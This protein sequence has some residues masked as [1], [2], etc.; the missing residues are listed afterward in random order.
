MTKIDFCE[1]GRPFPCKYKGHKM[2][3]SET[4]RKE[5]FKAVK[6]FSGPS[7]WREENGQFQAIEG[8]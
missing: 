4:Y 8:R 7:K 3:D 5:H 6:K 1:C 2:F